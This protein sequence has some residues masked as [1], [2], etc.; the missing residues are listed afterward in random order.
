MVAEERRL[1]FALLAQAGNASRDIP[2]TAARRAFHDALGEVDGDLAIKPFFP[3]NFL[4]VCSSQGVRDRLLAAGGIPVAGTVLAL[5]P[6]TRLVHANSTTLYKKVAVE[7]DGI[8]PHAWNMDTAAKLLSGSCWIERLAPETEQK[9]DLT[10]FKVQAWMEDP[11]SIPTKATLFVEEPE[12]PAVHSDPGMQLIFGRVT[13]FLR[14][15]VVLA[16]PTIIH[17]RSVTDFSPRSPSTSGNSSPSFDGDSGPEGNPDRS[18]GFRSET[19]PRLARFH[20]RRGVPDDEPA[21]APAPAPA[22]Q[23]RQEAGQ[24]RQTDSKSVSGLKR[25][26]SFAKGALVSQSLSPLA[27]CGDREA[28]ANGRMSPQGDVVGEERSGGKAVVACVETVSFELLLQREMPEER[29]SLTQDPM[30]N[31]AR[32]NHWTTTSL[33]HNPFERGAQPQ[34]LDA[35][36]AERPAPVQ[37]S[38]PAGMDTELLVEETASELGAPQKEPAATPSAMVAE[39]LI[40]EAAAALVVQ[41]EP[42]TTPAAASGFSSD[43]AQ[44]QLAQTPVA[45]QIDLAQT[46]EVIARTQGTRRDLHEQFVRAGDLTNGDSGCCKKRKQHK[47]DDNMEGHDGN[48]SVKL[49]KFLGAVKKKIASPLAAKPVRMKAPTREQINEPMGSGLPKRSRRIAQ[50]PLA[51]VASSKR[52]EIILMRRFDV[53]APTGPITATTRK[54]YHDFFEKKVDSTD[55]EAASELFP[56]LRR[57]LGVSVRGA[58]LAY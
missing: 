13:P 35:T 32:S 42:F 3:E 48:Q 31:E 18:Y 52:A 41:K 22:G 1:R 2:I 36:L 49:R 29:A 37:V 45:A 39:P 16:Y 10:T 38:E 58:Q 30:W 4:V 34:I 55:M 24:I 44:T 8:P 43:A 21:A 23:K 19:G 50:Q 47:K 20:C 11:R 12:T 14:Q 54:A 5:R 27:R 9:S 6:W 51:N 7:I 53:A 46:G 40:G 33:L 25:K 57:N 28:A 15:K 17:V 56:S 26:V